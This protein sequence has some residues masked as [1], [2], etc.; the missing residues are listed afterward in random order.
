[1]WSRRQAITGVDWRNPK[2]R[3][4]RA[5]GIGRTAMRCRNRLQGLS[6]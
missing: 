4:E 1:V 6:I 2:A 3:S 5:G